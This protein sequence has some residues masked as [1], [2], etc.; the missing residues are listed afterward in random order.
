MITDDYGQQIYSEDDV[1]DI[2]MNGVQY[3]HVRS[4]MVD[5]T[6]DIE[7]LACYVENLPEV[8]ARYYKSS[9]SV[10]HF[11]QKC[12]ANWRMPDEYKNL[13]IASYVLS[14]C[15][16]EAELQRCGE[17]LL[18]YQERGLFNLLQYL[19]YLVDTMREN[20]VIWGVGRGSSVASFVLYKLGVHKINSLYY[21]LN[22]REFL[23]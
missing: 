7:R 2:I 6:V 9:E 5:D 16:N 23:R 17:E 15:E 4:I 21:K 18:L 3:K 19:K 1:M 10:A 13:D 12:Q 8:F 11:D 14:L 20:R 22:I